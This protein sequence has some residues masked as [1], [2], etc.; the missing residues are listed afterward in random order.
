MTCM[1]TLAQGAGSR[2]F[3]VCRMTGAHQSPP[4]PRCIV[5]IYRAPACPARCIADQC[6][7]ISSS[8]STCTDTHNSSPV[9]HA[10]WTESSIAEPYRFTTEMRH[11]TLCL[12]LRRRLR[13]DEEELKLLGD[14]VVGVV[15]QLDALVRDV[16][17]DRGRA[18]D[19]AARGRIGPVNVD[20]PRASAGTVS[21][22][23][24]VRR[25]SYGSVWLCGEYAMTERKTDVPRH[26]P[27]PPL[28]GGRTLNGMKP[29]SSPSA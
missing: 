23:G 14:V 24:Q 11:L 9:F 22:R 29:P 10:N 28:H 17:L 5:K 18:R 21:M 4:R 1:L 6:A 19:V 13:V 3:P 26:G 15:V 8:P 2:M 20:L 25:T 16:E 12:V 27:Q 7:F